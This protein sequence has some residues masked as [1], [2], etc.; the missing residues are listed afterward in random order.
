MVPSTAPIAT[1]V[2]L[3]GVM[4]PLGYD[5]VDVVFGPQAGRRTSHLPTEV[6]A[7]SRKSS[8]QHLAEPLPGGYWLCRGDYHLGNLLLE[9]GA[10]GS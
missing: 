8:V 5:S 3:S 9:P 10:G 7:T 2:R 6:P 4:V 1:L